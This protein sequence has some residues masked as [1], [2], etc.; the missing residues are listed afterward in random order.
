MQNKYSPS[1]S[2]YLMAILNSL[3]EAG[4]IMT[5]LALSSSFIE[6][7]QEGFA[8]S[9]IQS[10]YYLGI[11]C[12]G[13]FGG[14]ILQKWSPF[15]L[16][17]AGPLISAI[18]AFFLAGLKSIALT[19]GLPAVFFICLLTGIQHPN[20]LRFFNQLLPE[21]RKISFFSFKEGITA[22]FTIVAPL[23][24]SLIITN[25][26]TRV[27]FIIDGMTYLICCTP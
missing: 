13:F 11:G 21:E 16:G 10:V 15:S 4:A 17:I 20:N 3:S 26:G 22:L 6:V 8:S 24:A 9:A 23:I 1:V 5:L 27:C 18:I 12:M 7:S 25:Y 2:L 19:I 14:A